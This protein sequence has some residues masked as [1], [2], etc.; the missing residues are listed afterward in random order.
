MSFLRNNDVKKHLARAVPR[1]MT[2]LTEGR[3]QDAEAAAVQPVEEG[4]ACTVSAEAP[5]KIRPM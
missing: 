4:I 2:P 3:A 5:E 1:S